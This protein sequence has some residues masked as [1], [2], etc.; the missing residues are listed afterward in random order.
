MHRRVVHIDTHED[1]GAASSWKDVWATSGVMADSQSRVIS[2]KSWEYVCDSP[3]VC[4]L[5][6]ARCFPFLNRVLHCLFGLRKRHY[7]AVY[8]LRIKQKLL[9]Q[10]NIRA[11]LQSGMFVLKLASGIAAWSANDCNNSFLLSHPC[12]IFF[13]QVM[14]ITF[15]ENAWNVAGLSGTTGKLNAK[16]SLHL[17]YI[18][19]FSILLSF[20]RLLFF[21]FFDVF[22]SDFR[23][24]YSHPHASGFTIIYQLFVS[25][26]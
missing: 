1:Y 11:F 7:W 21:A 20:S 23:F 18:S 8:A 4:R 2:S 5:D 13:Q 24:Y 10:R 14:S 17:A 15:A 12:K 6:A 16:S 3:G 9:L 25:V 19:L 22:S 26:G